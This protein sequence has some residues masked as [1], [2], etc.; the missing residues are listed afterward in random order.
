[1]TASDE[2]AVLWKPI[3]VYEQ[4]ID[5]PSKIYESANLSAVLPPPISYTASSALRE[6]YQNAR[7]S[8]FQYETV[9]CICQCLSGRKTFFLGDGTGCGKGRMI[10]STALEY[11]QR[12]QRV[13]WVSM[14]RRLFEDA[15]RDTNA[16]GSPSMKWG[17]FKTTLSFMTYMECMDEQVREKASFWLQGS[18]ECLIILDE[19]HWLRNASASSLC[20]REL[21]DSLPHA[22]ILYSSATA[23]SIPTHFR[24]TDGLGLWGERDSP[25]E[26]FGDFKAS[27]TKN[28]DTMMELVALHLKSRGVYVSRHLSM[29]DIEV[30]CVQQPLSEA[31]KYLYN[32]CARVFS[33]NNFTQGMKHQMFWQRFLAHTKIPIVLK[34][35]REELDRGNAVI[36]ALQNTGE[37]SDVR[38]VSPEAPDFVSTCREIFEQVAPNWALVPDFGLDPIDAILNEFGP[39]NV[40]EITGRRRR[41]G[42]GTDQK[43]VYETK[44]ST[45][46]EYRNFQS[47]RKDIAIL[48]RAGST[49]ISLHA[50]L[51]DSK[52]RVQ[53]CLE[54]PWSPEDFLQQCGRAHRASEIRLPVYKFVYTAIPS[55]LRFI[56]SMSHKLSNLGSLTKADRNSSIHFLQTPDKW[57]TAAKR[58]VAL[59]ICY[60]FMLNK[61][62]PTTPIPIVPHSRIYE[63]L[64]CRPDSSMNIKRIRLLQY[65]CC[66]IRESRFA[67]NSQPQI[68]VFDT[69]RYPRAIAA[70]RMIVSCH[71]AWSIGKFSAERSHQY[72]NRAKKTLVGLLLARQA[73]ECRNTLGSLPDSIFDIIYEQVATD[74]HVDSAALHE[75]FTQQMV[76]SMDRFPTM[77]NDTI[78]NRLLGLTIEDQQIF[79]NI[80]NDAVENNVG[81]KQ[82]KILHILDHYRK[83]INEDNLS[84]TPSI[85]GRTPTDFYIDVISELPKFP[86]L[87]SEQSILNVLTQQVH[88]IKYEDNCVLMYKACTT[89]PCRT[90]SSTQFEQEVKEG[91]LKPCGDSVFLNKEANRI[92]HLVQKINF[93]KYRYRIAIFDGLN[94]WDSSEKTLLSFDVGNDRMVGLLMSCQRI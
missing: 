34:M 53:I 42:V 76:S 14:N 33:T 37:A 82:R 23:A 51:P 24:Y 18:P 19:C 27:L 32:R 84:A 36:V 85:S 80:I 90:F 58:E 26:S 81:K 46:Q 92:R 17:K 87:A 12:D 5:H 65:V 78:Q 77:S 47:G 21:L 88:K 66:T 73:W 83:K 64:D 39:E 59:R 62:N 10:A 29:S 38:N 75:I 89:K 2:K 3:G 56:S 25:F 45:L 15:M 9:R 40:A 70:M 16:L 91:R 69:H 20:L 11:V 72:S 67:T 50:E 44:P 74:C 54:L 79:E 60:D 52:P 61:L 71:G 1:M 6:V 68:M 4:Y 28:G 8:T 41:I 94:R 31:T 55:E 30:H 13:L 48:S 63:L 86:D 57:S 22:K 7:I 43:K 49:G 93:S 35:I